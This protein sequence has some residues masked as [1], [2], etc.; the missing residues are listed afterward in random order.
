MDKTFEELDQ[1]FKSYSDLTQNQGQIRLVPGTKTRI[2]AFIQWVR[3]EV[4]YGRDPASIPFP[5]AD[6][7]SLIRR[8]K[9]HAKF[10]K[11]SSTISDAAKPKPFTEDM[12]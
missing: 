5:A 9:T 3:D 10:I 2:R 11:D 1:D 4:R 12:K 8:Y 7:A 6:A